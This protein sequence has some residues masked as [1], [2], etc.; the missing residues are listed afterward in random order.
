MHIFIHPHTSFPTEH[1]AHV[2][3]SH[4]LPLLTKKFINQ[5][6]LLKYPSIHKQPSVENLF[7]DEPV[8]NYTNPQ[9]LQWLTLAFVG[10]TFLAQRLPI[11]TLPSMCLGFSLYGH[12]AMPCLLSSCHHL[13]LKASVSIDTIKPP[14]YPNNVLETP[15]HHVEMS[16]EWKIHP[17]I[18]NGPHIDQLDVIAQWYLPLKPLP[19]PLQTLSWNPTKYTLL[20][21]INSMAMQGGGF[22]ISWRHL[23]S[24][25]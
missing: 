22:S 2:Q 6:V 17:L 13:I 7:H 4:G 9:S 19:I 10:S 24:W 18:P 1:Y 25:L 14:T 20:M 5:H 15:S 21:N 16:H 12:L 3:L 11:H 23:T 8:P